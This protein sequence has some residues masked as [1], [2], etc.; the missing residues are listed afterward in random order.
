MD[1]EDILALAIP[2]GLF[3]VLPITAMLLA[4]QRKMAELV[5][6]R[7]SEEGLAQRIER[8]E[9]SVV[10]LHDR[11]NDLTLSLDDAARLRLQAGSDDKA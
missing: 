2:F 8:L 5:S 7:R 4:H 11:L 9:D 1:F 3:V 6:Q 10:K